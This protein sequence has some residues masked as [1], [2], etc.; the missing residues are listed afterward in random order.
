MRGCVTKRGKTWAFVVEVGKHPVTGKRKQKWRSGFA[1][2]A[3]AEQELAKTLVELGKGKQLFEATQETVA[4]YMQT[5]LAHKKN[6]IRP[7]T[8]TT[9]DWGIR[10]H[11]EPVLGSVQL[12]KLQP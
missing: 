6:Q 5:W 7:G 12:P 3:E 4:S 1:S 9:Y 10:I 11:I 8:Y 2:K